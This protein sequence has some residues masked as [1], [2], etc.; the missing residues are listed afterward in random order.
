M[1]SYDEQWTRLVL[2]CARAAAAC[3][4]SPCAHV[5]RTAAGILRDIQL[6]VP[7]VAQEVEKLKQA[8]VCL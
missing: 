2:E 7:A 8:N 6:S 3:L 5:R 4:Q 1:C